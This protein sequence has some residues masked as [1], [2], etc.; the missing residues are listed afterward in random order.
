MEEVKRIFESRYYVETHN[1]RA[2][3][4]SDFLI[5]A[6]DYG[7]LCYSQLSDLNCI[8]KVIMKDFQIHYVTYKPSILRLLSVCKYGFV[9][10]KAFD[11]KI[12]AVDLVKFLD[13]ISN[14]FDLFKFFVFKGFDVKAKQGSIK[15]ENI[16]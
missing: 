12:F 9:R 14:F 5:L 15:I 7:G 4:F 13:L 16:N 10:E 2:E 6:E 1:R 11:D 3:A 8:L